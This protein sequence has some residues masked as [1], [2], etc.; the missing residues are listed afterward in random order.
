VVL[1]HPDGGHLGGGA[2]VWQSLPI[3]S[4]VVPV[5]S[6]RS[7]AYRAWIDQ[8]PQ[9]GVR[10]HQAVASESL[11]FPDDAVLEVLHVSDTNDA[12]AMADQRVAIYRLHWRG[13][14]FLFTSDA[15][16]GA[17]QQMLDARVEMKA[18][19]IIAGKHRSDL[20]LTD[21]FVNA[22]RPRVILISNDDYPIE[23]RIE[24]ASIAYWRSHGILVIDQSLTG[25]EVIT[26]DD[27]GRMVMKGVLDEFPWVVGR[28]RGR[29]EIED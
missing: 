19:V 1:T 3:N 17:E 2:A 15:G 22:V 26:M 13:W 9:A 14:K 28:G 11:P 27:A 16:L 12:Q 21:A 8:A 18:D 5:A 4:A 29:E 7:T 25:G 23:E 20:S 6:G 24:P 10:L